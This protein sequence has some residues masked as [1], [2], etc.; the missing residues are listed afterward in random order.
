M[1]R[2]AN[3][4]KRVLALEAKHAP[5]DRWPP[6]DGDPARRLAR[7]TA[8]FEGR[9]WDCTGNQERKAQ[10]DAKLACYQIY[11]DNLGVSVADTERL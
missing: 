9:P 8:Y 7:Y 2:A 4:E 11:F 5:R 3:F 6:R 10:R 1:I